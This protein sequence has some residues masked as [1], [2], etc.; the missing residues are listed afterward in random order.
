MAGVLEPYFSNRATANSPYKM[1]IDC[2]VVEITNLAASFFLSNTG[3]CD[4]Q[5][6]L[7]QFPIWKT[8]GRCSRHFRWQCQEEPKSS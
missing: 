2:R 7:L 6:H 1:E 3:T 4:R 5:Q 8:S